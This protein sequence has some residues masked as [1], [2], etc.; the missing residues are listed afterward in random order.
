MQSG[1]IS[2][3]LLVVCVISPCLQQC[4]ER[5]VHYSVLVTLVGKESPLCLAVA[6]CHPRVIIFMPC[7]LGIAARASEL[8]CMQCSWLPPW[9]VSAR[10]CGCPQCPAL[11]LCKPTLA[12]HLL[13]PGTLLVRLLILTSVMKVLGLSCAQ[14]PCGC[15]ACDC[16]VGAACRYG[17]RRAF[18]GGREAA[19]EHLRP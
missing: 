15:G 17:S 18:G 9:G 19:G 6:C 12:V 13:A 2:L 1:I 16:T 8:G 4:I 11:L 14:R 7:C 5:G 3:A 10:V